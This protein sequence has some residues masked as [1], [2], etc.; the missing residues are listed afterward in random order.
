MASL[1][2]NQAER[3]ELITALVTN[4]AGWD[5]DDIDIL[6]N[7]S[8]DKLWAHAEGCAKL[9]A[10]AEIED[11]GDLPDS[12]EPSSADEDRSAAEE[13][14]DEQQVEGEEGEAGPTK[15]HPDEEK[16]QPKKCWDEEGNEVDCGDS[17]ASGEN[18]QNEAAYLRNLPPRIQSVVINALKFE[19]TQKQQLVG[20]ITANSRNRFSKDYL[21]GMGLEE[22]Q[23]L[24]DLAAPKRRAQPIYAGAQGGPVFNEADIDRE[25]IL[26]VPVLEFTRN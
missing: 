22:L 21:M 20:Q 14:D 1:T 8:N 5:Q 19:H 25:D 9:V 16:D 13:G 17:T 11:S 2:L 23:A 3:K 24:A 10:N 7:M 6:V 18:V 15:T 26:T 12:L 4:C